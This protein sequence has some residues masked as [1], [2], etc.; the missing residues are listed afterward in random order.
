MTDVTQ[1]LCQI[2]QGD[3]SAAQELLPLVYGHL[4]G[5][6]ERYLRE[7][8]PDHTLQPT[9]LVHEAYVRL[10]DVERARHWHS[11]GHFFAAAAEAMRRILVDWAR[12]R[13]SLKRGGDWRRMQLDD[14]AAGACDTPDLLLDLDDGL[15]RL[16]EEDAESA[17]LVKLRLFAGLSVTEAGCALGL[18][19]TVAYENWEFARS[20]FATHLGVL[21]H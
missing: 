2:E 14:L 12:A 17:E 20:W 5:L 4:R 16:A 18:S 10:V 19:R 8:R 6:A 15:C 9:A 21:S 3:P 7:E 13:K 11:R 1:Y